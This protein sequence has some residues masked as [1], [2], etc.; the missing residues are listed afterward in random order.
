MLPKIEMEL[1]W[2][3]YSKISY[4]K[5][6]KLLA[7]F[8]RIRLFQ[9]ALFQ[10]SNNFIANAIQDNFRISQASK[11]ANLSSLP[12]PL[13]NGCLTGLVMHLNIAAIGHRHMRCCFRRCIVVREK[14]N[15]SIRGQSFLCSTGRFMLL[16][17]KVAS[18]AAGLFVPFC[19]PLFC[20]QRLG[21]SVWNAGK[22]GKLAM[23]NPSG[24]AVKAS[25][26]VI[27]PPCNLT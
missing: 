22:P 14:L 15:D 17:G 2:K 18:A 6:Q 5:C 1:V 4:S 13:P 21:T 11:L 8:F 20:N 24:S 16:L 25:D 27:V 7:G 3:I 26:S 23:Q 10:L 9:G 19:C 12:I